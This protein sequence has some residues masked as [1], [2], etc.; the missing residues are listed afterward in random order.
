MTSDSTQPTPTPAAEREL[1]VEHTANEFLLG[2]EH[3]GY[4]SWEDAHDQRKH[5][6]AGLCKEIRAHVLAE[7][8]ALR[9]EL[10]IARSDID[11][12]Q[13][14]TDMIRAERDRYKAAL[15]KQLNDIPESD[16][17]GRFYHANFDDRGNHISLKYC[18]PLAVVQ[19]LEDIARV[20][21]NPKAP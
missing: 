9:A 4:L 6:Q 19:H 7:T 8:A 5:W 3:S 16:R 18:A 11:A 17:D 2:L 20:A 21:L 15:E 14:G 13:V 1:I 12:I 10:A